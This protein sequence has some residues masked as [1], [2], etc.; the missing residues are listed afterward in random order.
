MGV[1]TKAFEDMLKRLNTIEDLLIYPYERELDVLF[2]PLQEKAYHLIKDI[3]EDLKKNLEGNE[4][5]LI[6]RIKPP[7]SMFF[8]LLL[9]S[10]DPKMLYDIIAFRIYTK[11]VFQSRAIYDRLDK[12]YHLS[13]DL[14]HIWRNKD[15]NI[16]PGARDYLENPKS[17][18]YRSLDF[19]NQFKDGSLFEIQTRPKAFEEENKRNYRIYKKQRFEEFKASLSDPEAR[20]SI[21]NGFINFFS[22]AE[23]VSKEDHDC[24]L[25]DL[26][27]RYKPL[28]QSLYSHAM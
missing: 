3:E 18:G 6:K 22:N 4:H 20:D 14:D 16:R 8:K 23:K 24:S 26:C 7:G 25:Y 27:L 12:T 15:S 1:N 28:T 11:D 9:N 2:F 13:E 19:V 5:E 10:F 17:T 21:V